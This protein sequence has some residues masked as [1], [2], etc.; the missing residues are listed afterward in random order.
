MT[1]A[2]LD[3][4][5]L[6]ITRRGCCCCWRSGVL[7]T[8]LGE[9]H[10]AFLRYA[11]NFRQTPAKRQMDYLR[12]AA[13]SREGAK[14]LKLFNLSDFFTD[15]FNDALAT[16]LRRQC[17]ALAHEADRRRPAGH[18]RH[19]R[20]L[21]RVRLR[22]LAR[23]R[24]PLQSIGVYTLLTNADHPG[25]LESAAGLLDGLGRCRPGAVPYRP[26]GLLRDEADGG[27]E[28]GWVADA[29]ADPAGF[30]FRNV[31]FAY[32]GTERRVLQQLQ[33]HACAGRAHC[34]DRRERPGQDDGRE[35]DHAA[36]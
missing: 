7:P 1:T 26:A 17:R 32:P 21:R 20:L 10:F 15:R 24:R 9:T 28:G 16:D 11:K 33:L 2:D 6:F 19:A 36:V 3:Q 22:H 5:S 13:G 18:H 23:D 30:E 12:Q 35:A 34:A 31:S 29:A 8:F 4:H 25:E 27:V 14:E